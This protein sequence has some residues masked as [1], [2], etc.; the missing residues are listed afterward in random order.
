MTPSWPHIRTKRQSTGHSL[1]IPPPAATGK[2]R[3]ERLPATTAAREQDPAP[4][5]RGAARA[6]SVD[7]ARARCLALP[8]S[9]TL[10][11]SS[12]P[13]GRA[14]LPA[15]RTAPHPAPAPTRPWRPRPGAR[16]GR[17]AL[18]P[19]RAARRHC[20]ENRGPRGRSGK[21][22][23]R[24]R[25]RRRRSPHRLRPSRTPASSEQPRLGALEAAPPR[26]LAP[27]SS[28]TAQA[29]STP[30]TPSGVGGAQVARRWAGP[31]RCRAGLEER[32]QMPG[33]S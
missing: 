33:G 2:Q 10:P 31:E 19:A 9:K 18:T 20:G 6:R 23:F 28:R 32:K 30:R 3:G 24:G 26:V 8:C 14:A 16:G 21:V 25:R 7:A 11:P 29:Q 17:Q 13:P 4:P 22:Y 1:P 12:G 15:A 27:P 5:P